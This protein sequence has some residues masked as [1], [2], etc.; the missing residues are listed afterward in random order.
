MQGVKEREWE[1]YS[2]YDDHSSD[3]DNAADEYFRH[4]TIMTDETRA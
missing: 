3:D 2:S 4:D 1:T